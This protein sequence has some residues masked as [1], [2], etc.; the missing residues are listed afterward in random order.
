MGAV[1]S[2]FVVLQPI[3]TILVKT[4]FLVYNTQV[5]WLYLTISLFSFRVIV[6]QPPRSRQ[7]PDVRSHE[8]PF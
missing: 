2:P 7:N 6:P 3:D 1:V 5:I 4:Q 8:V